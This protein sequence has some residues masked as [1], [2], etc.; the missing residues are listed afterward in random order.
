MEQETKA[1]LMKHFQELRWRLVRIALAVVIGV[2][3]SLYFADDIIN[4]LKSLTEGIE[5]QSIDPTEV[6]GTYFNLAVICGF[7]FATPVILY[8]IV[9]FIRPALSPRERRNLFTLL[10]S[11]VIAFAIGVA[12]AYY[13]LLPPAI[14]F[15]HDFG[16]N[17]A[18]PEWR[19][20]KYVTMITRLLFVIGLCFETPIIMYFLTRIGILT[21]QKL[22]RFR[23]WAVLLAFLIAAVATPT[24]DP[25]NQV[26]VAVP[27]YL[28]YEIGIILSRIAYRGKR[29]PS[30][31]K[32]SERSYQKSEK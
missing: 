9:M 20:S 31:A 15:L 21:P 10:P 23:R 24:P 22:S 7:A 3:L 2:G 18:T 6:I 32:P 14:D 30:V 17:V 13:V 8:E 12:F 16:S 19:I 26:I 29:K 11:M 27:L 28:L 1:P 25:I 4:T 5:L